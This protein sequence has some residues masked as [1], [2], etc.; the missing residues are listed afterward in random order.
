MIISEW[1]TRLQKIPETARE[2]ITG[3]LLLV[4]T[5]GGAV[6]VGRVLD[7]IPW[8]AAFDAFVYERINLGPHPVWLDTIVSPFNFNFLPWG[9]TFIP[10]F[11]YFVFAFGL[12]YI[13]IRYRKELLW[14]CIAL[15]GAIVIDAVLF[16]LTNAYVVRDRPFIHLPNN[17]T[18]NA[19]AIWRS[20]PTYPSGHV[21]DMALYSTVLAG[22]AHELRWPFAL[23]TLWIV[24]TRIYIGAHYPTDALAGWLIG[25]LVGIA[26]LLLIKPLHRRFVHGRKTGEWNTSYV[27]IV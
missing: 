9:G 4:V 22:F 14:A 16:K 5:I 17:L 15:L 3:L 18:E 27:K 6:A 26:I 10:S 19:K 21:R 12:I 2:L 25:Y 11:L 23:L 20:W 8:V 7:H 1:A 13:G 24:F